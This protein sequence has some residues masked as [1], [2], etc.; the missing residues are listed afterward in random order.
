MGYD[1][2]FPP[3]VPTILSIRTFVVIN[4]PSNKSVGLA[5]MARGAWNEI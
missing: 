5:D 2:N 1:F 4:I 3:L